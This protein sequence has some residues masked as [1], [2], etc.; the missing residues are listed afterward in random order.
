MNIA[1]FKRYFWFIFGFLGV[2]FFWVGLYDGSNR[3]PY[4]KLWWVSLLI[5]LAMFVF[6]GFFLRENSMVKA[7]IEINTHPAI[8]IF[9][10]IGRHPEKQLKARFLFPRQPRTRLK[11]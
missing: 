10:S 3:L 4:L 8:K 5:G 6:S 1:T 7:A 11:L 2:T 9:D